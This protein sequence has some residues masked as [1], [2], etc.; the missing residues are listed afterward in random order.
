MAF[1]GLLGR[2]SG[3]VPIVMSLAA[4]ALVLL[5]VMFFDA[6]H[7]AD[8][9]SAAHLWQL[10]V[11]GQLPV[12]VFFA[13]KWLPRSARAALWVLAAQAFALLAAIAP[14]YLLRL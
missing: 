13:T 14:V 6:A 2:P 10:L 3:F 5:A 12:I 9:G 7:Q 4:L 11:A 8:E 1:P